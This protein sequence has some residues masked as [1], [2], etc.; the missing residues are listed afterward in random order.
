MGPKDVAWLRLSKAR[1]FL[2]ERHLAGI[3]RA[4]YRQR[5]KESG[6]RY[7]EE[8]PDLTDYRELTIADI[9]LAAMR[10]I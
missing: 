6:Q 4:R 10:I 8:P 5:M 1:K 9:A 3:L 7:V 2:A